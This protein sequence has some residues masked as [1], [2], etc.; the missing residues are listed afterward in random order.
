MGIKSE[1]AQDRLTPDVSQSK[2][3]ATDEIASRR[4]SFK[5]ALP[6]GFLGKVLDPAHPMVMCVMEEATVAAENLKEASLVAAA[7][8][9]RE[10]LPEGSDEEFWAQRLF[11]VSPHHAQIRAIKRELHRRRDWEAEPF[12]GTVDKMSA[13][14][15]AVVRASPSMKAN[16]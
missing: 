13:L 16:W 12:V 5:G 1:S 9:L 3:P 15:L 14:L 2:A 8:K 7:V 10:L 6:E 4:L 11:I